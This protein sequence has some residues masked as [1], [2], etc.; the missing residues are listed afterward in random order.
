MKNLM[1]TTALVIAT[2]VPLS[3]K[4][5]T[6]DRV[7]MN[8]GDGYL[9]P[10]EMLA[11]DLIGMPVYA[12][13]QKITAD[14]M[15]QA[16]MDWDEI[17]EVGDVVMSRNGEAEAVLMDIGGFLG[18]GEKTVAVNYDQL[19]FMTARDGSDSFFLVVNASEQMM[20]EAE[21]FNFEQLGAWTSAAWSDAKATASAAMNDASEA[22]GDAAGYVTGS[23]TQAVDSMQETAAQTTDSIK[24]TTENLTED[25]AQT[26]E[27]AAASVEQAAGELGA[28]TNLHDGFEPVDARVLTSEDLTGA[29]VYDIRAEWIGEVS[30]LVLDTNGQVEKAVIDVGGFLG[31]GEKPVA[32]EL[33]SLTITRAS[34]GDEV[35]VYVDASRT[36]LEEMP[37]YSGS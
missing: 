8:Y 7:F 1:T 37:A 22:A 34:E 5:T 24:Q 33:D 15:T 28:P 30:E 2:A 4:D 16:P 26:V 36:E 12:S 20:E 32:K 19:H 9:A 21:P 17:G 11:S 3:A 25:A 18:I 10:A 6:N 35:R 14:R 27:R 29:A 23:A 13:E 31:L